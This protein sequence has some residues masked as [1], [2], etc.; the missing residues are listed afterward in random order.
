M[1]NLNTFSF[2]GA[3]ASGLLPPES[4]PT[5]MA[6]LLQEEAVLDDLQGEQETLPN[7]E[8]GDFRP[9]EE[10]ETLP[11]IEEGD[12]TRE[13]LLAT[14]ESVAKGVSEGTHREYMK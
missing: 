4:E 10:Q 5:N 9:D 14:L 13:E 8:E 3:A 7:L 12:Q 11:D 2:P 1:S 6:Q